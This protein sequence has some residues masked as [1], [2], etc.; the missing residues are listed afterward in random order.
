MGRTQPGRSAGITNDQFRRDESREL[1]RPSGASKPLVR[2][3]I[4]GI[5]SR[6]CRRIVDFAVG[7][8]TQVAGSRR[9]VS[10]G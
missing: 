7:R 6:G 3:G 5:L 9:R 4:L 10:L 1:G 2:Q 8:R